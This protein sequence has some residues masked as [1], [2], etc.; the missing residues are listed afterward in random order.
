MREA[1]SRLLDAALQELGSPL[2]VSWDRTL[3]LNS[4]GSLCDQGS[5]GDPSVV[6]HG[7]HL[8]LLS[9]EGGATHYCK[10]RRTLPDGGERRESRFLRMF[11]EHPD[12][13]HIVPRQGHASDGSLEVQ[14]TEFIGVPRMD[15]AVRLLGSEERLQVTLQ[16]LDGAYLLTRVALESQPR[17]FSECL[18]LADEAESLLSDLYKL[19]VTEKSV[20]TIRGA[21]R[22]A[23]SIPSL[24]QH[25]DLW[26]VNIFL[27]SEA[28][29]RIIDFDGF[30]EVRVP[31]HDTFHLLRTVGDLLG[32]PRDGPWC[33]SLLRGEA[34]GT[35]AIRSAR[36]RFDLSTR[37]VGGCL[38]YYLVDIAVGMYRRGA[39]REFWGRFRDE[40]PTIA[41]VLDGER[42]IE[43][44]GEHISS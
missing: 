36:M 44:I 27:E 39:P 12:T 33:E 25:R 10:C 1:L 29:F 22:S 41:R 11:G 6:D 40:I 37:Q 28:G 3:V 20:D 21:L 9:P 8:L 4:I 31:L 7:F 43:E 32:Q 2:G 13:R 15:H 26:P 16:V 17:E 34:F 18:R 42:A 19:E 30:G 38:L 35:E 14:V 23:G 24:P 5:R